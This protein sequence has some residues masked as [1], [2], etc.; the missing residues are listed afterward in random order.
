MISAFTQR[1]VRRD[2]AMTGEITLR[3]EVL[4]IGGVKEKVLAA[5]A[6]KITTII[7]PQLN[8]RDVAQISPRI[9]HDI[10]FRYVDT[11]D[12]VLSIALL[13]ARAG[14]RSRTPR[15]HGD[16]TRDAAGG[17]SPCRRPARR[18][19]PAVPARVKPEDRFVETLRALL[20]ASPTAS[21]SDPATTPRWSPRP[22]EALVAT[23]DLLVEGVD[24]LPDED[25]ERIGRRAVAVNLSDLAAM[26]A[27]PAFFLLS[28]GFPAERGEE[29]PLAIA[30][31]ALSRG[32]EFGAH[33][34]GGDLS[35]ARQV[36]VSIA[37]WGTPGADPRRGG[38]AARRRP[39]PLG[40][41]GRGRRGPAAGADDRGV[42]AGG[43]D[44]DPRPELSA[45]HQHRLLA[46]FQ[47]PGSPR[48]ARRSLA[49]EGL[50]TAAI[51]VSDGLG[52]D[53]GRLAR[54]SGARA[55]CWKQTGSLCRVL[56]YPS[57][58]WRSSTPWS[59]RSRAE[60]TT[61]CSSPP[62]RRA[63]SGWKT[64]PTPSAF[65]SRGSGASSRGQAR[66]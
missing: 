1:L 37:L 23:T 38:R 59:S 5:R 64:A 27:P 15:K 56:S 25:P 60:T 40:S 46:A 18:R 50:A 41:S 54:A 58:R 17:R 24:F 35:A 29:F 7:L 39:L 9:L 11:V 30:R 26:G 20:P 65:R 53:A 62:R 51:D 2:V 47:E 13:P 31:G 42:L 57:R 12:E 34:V 45:E 19:A 28:I 48:R 4:P 14:R 16:P 21:S 32:A 63:P 44:A 43:N 10:E 52:I 33:L 8:R 3:G 49:V 36:I 22:E 55:S 61:S 66:R 6:A